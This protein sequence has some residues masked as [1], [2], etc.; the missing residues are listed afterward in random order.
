MLRPFDPTRKNFR[1]PLHSFRLAL[2]LSQALITPL[3]LLPYSEWGENYHAIPLMDTRAWC[4]RVGE[5]Q[6][7]SDRAPQD[8]R[9]EEAVGSVCLRCAVGKQGL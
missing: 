2:H 7:S 8:A 1:I 4:Q 9:L 5:Q 3:H 6:S